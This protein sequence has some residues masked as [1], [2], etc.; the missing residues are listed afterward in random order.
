MFKRKIEKELTEWKESLKF[1]KK[2]FILKG[3]RQIGKTTIIKEFA[4]KKF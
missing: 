2:A 1:K 3:M 4:K